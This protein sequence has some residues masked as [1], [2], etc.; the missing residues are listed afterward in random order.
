M[1]N[2]AVKSQVRA[3]SILEVTVA[4]VIIS[5]AFGIFMTIYMNILTGNLYLQ[6]LKYA[7]RLTVLRQEFLKAAD[8]TSAV[9]EDGPVRIFREVSPYENNNQL[10]FIQ[11]KAIDSNGKVVAHTR[12]LYHVN[13]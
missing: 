4:L 13:P 5:I 9:V 10:L 11:F 1:L 7:G 8:F 12:F 6:K 3:S 2:K